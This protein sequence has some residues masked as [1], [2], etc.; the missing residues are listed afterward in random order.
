MGR[1]RPG[2]DQFEQEIQHGALFVGSPE[3][4]ADKIVRTKEALGLTR[5][6]LKYGNGSLAHEHM[7]ET[8]ELY[9]SKVK[10]L[11]LEKLGDSALSG[12][13]D[14]TASV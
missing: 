14:R 3:T 10:P 13:A 11:V 5:F 6:G 9:G 8:I 2:R 4:V 1:G 12:H 7:M